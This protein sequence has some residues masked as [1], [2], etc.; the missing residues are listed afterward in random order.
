M[1]T[2]LDSWKSFSIR[3]ILPSLIAVG[4]FIG[5]IYVYMIPVFEETMLDQKRE[6]ISELTNSAWSIL[7][8]YHKEQVDSFLTQEQAQEKALM[9]IMNVRYGKNRKDYFWIND[10][11][12]KMIMHPYRTNLNGNDLSEFS[13]PNGKKIFLDFV[14]IVNEQGSGYLD[15]MWQ[16]K[17]DSTKIVPKLSY[18]KGF[19]PWSWVIGTGI[20]VEDVKAEIVSIEQQLLLIFGG[21]VSIIALMLLIIVLQSIRIERKK[22]RTEDELIDSREQYRALVEITK[23]GTIMI[24]EG[25]V[26][27]S[28][29]AVSKLLGYTSNELLA[30]SMTEL[31]N[32]EFDN[33]GVLL[34]NEFLNNKDN[35]LEI[36]TQLL[37]KDKS[38]V[39]VSI[40][41]SRIV[42]GDKKG[43]SINI[44][45][46]SKDKKVEEELDIKTEQFK[47]LTK[48]IDV[49]V[50]RTSF[51]NRASFIEANPATLK[52]L[53]YESESELFKQNIFDLFF[54]RTD[55]KAFFKEL[56]KEKR[57]KKKTIQIQ[58]KDGVPVTVSVSITIVQDYNGNNKYCDGVVE[59]VTIKK[60][61]EEQKEHVFNELQASQF[62]MNQP[63]S[64]FVQELVKCSLD[65]SIMKAAAQMSKKESTAVIVQAGNRCIGIVTDYD[66]RKR[67][68]A[69]GIDFKKPISE[70]MSAPIITISQNAF[71][72]EAVMLMHESKVRHLCVKNE[73]NVITHILSSKELRQLQVQSSSFIIKDIHVASNVEGITEARQ[74]LHWIVKSMIKSGATSKITTGVLSSVFNIIVEKLVAFA[75]EDLGEAP[76]KFAFIGLGSEGRGEETLLTD[77]DNA[78]I[79]EDID[80]GREEEVK[81]YFDKLGE[82]LSDWLAEIGYSYCKGEIMAKN[83]K[84]C[85][86]LSVWKQYFT[87]WIST[88]EPSD[89]LEVNIFFDYKCL[90]GD[91]NL[92]NSLREH[93]NEVI[94][95]CPRFFIFISQNTLQYKP[96]LNIFGNIILKSNTENIDTFSIKK[97]M[98]PIVS[99]VRIYAIQNNISQTNTLER[100]KVLHGRKVISQSIYNEILY[101]YNYLMQLR[102]KHQIALIEKGKEPDNDIDPKALTNIDQST[103][104]KVF[105]QMQDFQMKLKSDFLGGV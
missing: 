96:P 54:N 36:E 56:I 34:F 100:L 29:T 53:G 89:L 92:T 27:Y 13:D 59:D 90:Y 87:K 47:S 18:V 60:K 5:S 50:F 103:I 44:R 49:G 11:Q 23:E 85:Q 57:V 61:E 7:E 17:D 4:L 48:N 14:N 102:L 21:I 55:K 6:M 16:W 40:G 73:E 77:Q 91:S 68:V 41:M 31:F 84:Y 62:F 26:V 25:K 33:N 58:K 45:D 94:E 19:A 98:M 81:A 65:T 15:Y 63:I 46:I 88:A 80:E 24:L 37:H 69:E 51:G 35:N 12:P 28:N 75:I 67:V 82:K 39:N 93:V 10:M 72:F 3:I 71:V 52:I 86:P 1:K 64:M 20:Y 9:E 99:F 105:A 30:I 70:I 32:S 78:I 97:A 43:V 101:V 42:I 104:K 76:V 22:Q 66:L 8:N 79:Y 38:I 74:N 83:P 95:T 2:K